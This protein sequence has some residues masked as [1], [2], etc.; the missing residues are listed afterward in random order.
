MKQLISFFEIPCTDFQRAVKF[1]KDILGL[2]MAVFDEES[3]KMACF[4]ESE[5]NVGG[6]ISFSK[7]L[8]PSSDGVLISF[9]AGNDLNEVLAKAEKFGGKIIKS[10]TKIEAEGKGYFAMISDSEGNTVGL[11]SDN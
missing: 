1:Y 10:K 4:P 2:Q 9:Y 3:E 11:Y 6:A 8:K 7:E 5:Y